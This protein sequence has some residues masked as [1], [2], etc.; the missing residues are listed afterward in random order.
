MSVIDVKIGYSGLSHLGL[1]HAVA[2]AHKG[3]QVVAKDNSKHKVSDLKKNKI[4]IEEPNLHKLLKSGQKHLQFTTN[5]D[6]LAKCEI[7]FISLDVPTDNVGVSDLNLIHENLDQTLASLNKDAVLVILSQVPPGFTRKIKKRHTD[8]EIYYQVET[9]IFGQAIHRA[10]NP[11]RFIIG[12]ADRN[13]NLN[14]NYYKF[15]DSFNCPILPMTYESAELTKIS[16]NAFLASSVSMSNTLSEISEIVG[17][18]WFEII[19][20]LR[21]DNRIGPHSY[22]NPGLGLSGGNL[23]RDLKTLIQIGEKE[24]SNVASVRAILENSEHQKNWLWRTFTETRISQV[25]GSKIA[26]LGLSYKENTSSTKNSSAV[27]FILKLSNYLVSA[28]DPKAKVKLPKFVTRYDEV[29]ECIQGVDLLVIATPW[30]DYKN[31]DVSKIKKVMSGRTVID[32]FR[33]LNYQVAIDLG[34]SYASLGAEFQF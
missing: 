32:P 33:L 28:H 21:L 29:Y 1:I 25:Y 26:I 13:K 3:A 2:V 17:A 16:I 24:G 9:L 5:S 27:H 14:L 15:L 20:A 31:L 22:L 34:F 7:V 19:P 8:I 10:L 6:E 4:D 12:C 18:D 30:P 23:E 11:E